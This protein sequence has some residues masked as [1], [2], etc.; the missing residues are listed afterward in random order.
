MLAIGFYLGFLCCAIFAATKI[1][2]AER[3]WCRHKG[4]CSDLLAG[5]WDE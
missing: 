4:D 2:I 5:E 3:G 1:A